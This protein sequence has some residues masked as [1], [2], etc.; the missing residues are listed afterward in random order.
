MT[1]PTVHLL[2]ATGRKIVPIIATA[3]IMLSLGH[4]PVDAQGLESEKAI[5]AI[6]GSEVKTDEARK[7][8]DID[9]VVK[10]ITNSRQSAELARK[11]YNIDSLE[12]IFVPEI[13]EGLAKVLQENESD[14][15]VLRESIEGSAIFYHAIDSRSIILTN[16]IAAEFV[17]GSNVTIF[18]K[19]TSD[20]ADRNIQTPAVE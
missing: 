20:T 7:D 17:D 6:V 12:L 19:G 5:D 1:F 18:V 3:L 2:S 13:D 8:G 15:Q 9:R 4:F 14:I 11:A 10:A 16:I